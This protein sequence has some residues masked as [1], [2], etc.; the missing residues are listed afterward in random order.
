[1][2][3]NILNQFSGNV[4]KASAALGYSRAWFYLK[5]QEYHIDIKN[6][7]K[8]KKISKLAGTHNNTKLP[9]ELV[10]TLTAESDTE[11]EKVLLDIIKALLA[12]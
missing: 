6:F 10:S 3:M 2:I 9:Q 12:K 11:K 4:A 5:F 7:R 8:Q 1:M